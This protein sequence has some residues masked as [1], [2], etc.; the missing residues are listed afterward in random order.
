M[1]KRIYPNKAGMFSIW[2]LFISLIQGHEIGLVGEMM[3]FSLEEILNLFRR[4]RHYAITTQ[5][6]AASSHD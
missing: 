1:Q 3:Q 4:Y 2:V 6:S 5:T